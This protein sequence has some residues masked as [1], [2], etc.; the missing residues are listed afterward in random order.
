MKK[1][2]V[3]GVI[4]FGCFRIAGLFLDAGYSHKP[5]GSFKMVN[6]KIILKKEIVKGMS[7]ICEQYWILSTRRV[8][9][10]Q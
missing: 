2:V 10:L 1:T 8:Q 4:Q 5:K 3:N 9:L 7:L 6:E